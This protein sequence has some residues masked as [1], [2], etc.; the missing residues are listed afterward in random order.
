ML[1]SSLIELKL[2]HP[3]M[4]TF[5][6]E[7]IKPIIRQVEEDY[8]EEILGEEQ[9]NVLL[10]DYT[11]NLDEDT[12]IADR[13]SMVPELAAL[14]VKCCDIIAPVAVFR[15]LSFANK[16]GQSGLTKIVPDGAMSLAKWE[17]DNMLAEAEAAGGRA[18]E[19]LYKFLEKNIDDYDEWATSDAYVEFKNAFIRNVKQFQKQFNIRDSRKIFVM[20]QPAMERVAETRIAS[21]LGTGLYD[22]LREQITDDDVSVANKK[23]LKYIES[24][25]ANLAWADT[26]LDMPFIFDSSGLTLFE[27]T[28]GASTKTQKAIPLEQLEASRQDKK[29]IGEQSLTEL[30]G[31][32]YKNH[33]DYPLFEADTDAYQP[34]ESRTLTIDETQK[35]KARF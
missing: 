10:E 32:L 21:I 22:A 15:Y 13:D 29:R 33:A 27:N 24:A 30:S 35:V 31:F 16:P 1:I 11:N 14:L 17:F 20:L 3:V 23:L 28:S 7:D 2:H 34:D 5:F 25:I 19:R 18:V 6:Y 12:G 8:V 26:V 9:Y 4:V